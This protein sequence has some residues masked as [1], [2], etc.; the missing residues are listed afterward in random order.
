M[1]LETGDYTTALDN[2]QR[3]IAIDATNEDAKEGFTRAEKAISGELDEGSEELDL[4]S[5]DE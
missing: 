2:F 3:A 5:A 1:Y 4:Q